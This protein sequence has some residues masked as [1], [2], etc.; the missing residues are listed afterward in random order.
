ATTALTLSPDSGYGI[1]GVTGCDGTLSGST[2]TTSAVTADCTVQASF[3]LNTYTVDATAGTGGSIG[4][5]NATVDHGATMNFS[6]TPDTGYSAGSVTGCNGSFSGNTYTTGSVTANCTI[7]AS[8]ILNT[9]TVDT[10]TGT[11]GSIGPASTTVNHGTT[12]DLT[13]TPD[14]GYSIGSVTGC[15]GTLTGSTYTTDVITANCSV[16]ASFTLNTYTVNASAGAN[17]SIGPASATVN[18]GSTTSFTVTPNSLY[19]IASVTG[20]DGS[21]IGN[22]YTT[23][24][25]SADCTVVASFSPPT[26]T[27]TPKSIK[28]FSFSWTDVSGVIG[29]KLTENPDGESGYTEIIGL[30]ATSHDLEVSLP[31]RINASYILRAC[32][33][34]ACTDSDAVFVN[35]TLAEAVGY[36]KASNPSG[37]DRF[38]SSVAFSDDGNTLAVG[39]RDAEAVY[40]FTRSGVIWSQQAYIK[41][42]NTGAGDWF[43][44]ILALSSDGNTL[45]VGAPNEDSDAIGINGAQGD[46]SVAEQSGAVYLF[47]RSAGTWSQQAYIKASNTG[48]F[49]FFG[50][51]LALSGDGN[52]LAV[53]AS[54]EDSNATGIDGEQGD[55]SATSSGAVYVFTRS[56]VTWSQQAYVKASNTGSGDKFGSGVAISDDGNTLAVGAR[57]EDSNATGIDG[58][59]GNDSATASG[60]AFVFTRSGATWSQQAYIKASNTAAYDRFGTAIALAGDGNTLAVGAPDEDS[61]ATGINGAQGDNSATGSGAT[62]L[63]TRSGAVWSQQAY[64]KAS[65]TEAG[66]WFGEI[67]AL[68]GDGS[69]L[70]VGV[71]NEASN[72]IGIGGAQDDNSATKSGAVYLYSH[73]TGS[74]S[75]HAYVKASNTGANDEFGT[76]LALSDDGRALAIGAQFEDSSAPGI[77][78]AQDNNS[79]SGSGAVYLY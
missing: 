34:Y 20:C 52:T 11:G 66:D 77:G 76:A 29:Y 54:E 28:T 23:G 26:L 73:N 25:A 78:G 40:I 55:T 13:L 72:A 47:T 60:A 24:A 41:A 70:A 6:L 36:V 48:F 75:Q 31:A 14:T 59:Q 27:L 49:D 1:A 2:Y 21:L 10:T 8:F 33:F 63:Y 32:D 67:L 74:W 65:N 61:S 16:A 15:G 50:D 4:P 62:Y 46:T 17:G 7:Q 69:T 35:G 5:A 71:V 22:T 68:S 79:L 43:G 64:V 38:G 44:E 57:G 42:S 19:R 9:Y 18:H 51:A 58:A 12:T 45:A 53:G 39:A 30:S 37:G 3:T 56:G